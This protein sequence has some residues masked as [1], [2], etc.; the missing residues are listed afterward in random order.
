M[1]RTL[2]PRPLAV[3][4]RLIALGLPLAGFATSIA[5]Q[6]SVDAALELPAQQVTAS[7]A[8]R[9]DGPVDGYVA[10]RSVTGTKTDTPLLEVPQSISVITADRMQDQ[11]VQTVQDALRYVAGVRGEAFGLDTRGDWAKVRGS[12]PEL[13]LDGLQQ[14]FGYYNN[15]RTDPYT[16]ERIE[17]L[18][19]PSSM[20]Y[21]QSPVG[22]LVNLVS[23]RPQ[24]EPRTELQAQYGNYDHKQIALDSTGPLNEDGSLLYRVVAIAR[25]S[26][27]QVDYVESD[28]L[29]LM[30]SITWRPNDDI[31][32]TL[33]ANVQ[34]DDGGS[35]SQFL[36][37]EGTV[38]GAPYGRYDTDL[39]V[40][41][42]GFDEYDAEQTAL[43]SQ[44]SWRLNETWT[45]RQNL[46]YQESEV[47][48]QQIYGW[49]P[50]LNTDKRTLDRI[51]YVSKPEV[52][53]WVADHNAQALFDTGP[54][55]HTLLIGADYQH[56]VTNERSAG[57]AATPL[58]L[59]DPVY[60][61]FDPSV[62]SLVD[63]PEQT[64]VQQGIYVQDQLKYQRWLLTLGLRKDWADNRTDGGTRQKDDAVTGRVGLTYLFDNGVAPYISYSES[65]QPIIG[66][67]KA[68]NEPFTPLEGE[69]WEVGVKYQ[70]LG[71]RSLYTAA[72][73]DLRELNRQMP[74]PANP[75]NTLQA[76]ET[77][78]RGL[79]L[80]ALVSVTPNWDLIATYTHLDTEVI[81]GA[82]G[83]V[84]KRL[85]SIPENMASLWSQHQ[86]A[87]FGVPG[88]RAGA[89]VRYVGASWDGADDVK[90]PSTTLFDAMLGY[91][92]QNW[93]FAVN[94]T[95][96]EDETYYTSCLA[97]GDCFTGSRR[98]VVGT[99]SYSF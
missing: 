69:Q 64:V 28:R 58:D 78:T 55:Q 36:P 76:G 7:P 91:R 33:L 81:E 38:F 2:A 56:A 5:A 90:T 41:E 99:V 44:F 45:L 3:A 63:S 79:E 97:R 53:V 50:V 47:S 12:S 11:G 31:E 80:E 94:A 13:F 51:Y 34:R 18:K 30:P 39:F 98:T 77:R 49:P 61:T 42:P 96:L 82:P 62:I 68:N 21:G 46:R 84:G 74:D 52:D 22:G 95:N 25:D 37:H 8:E 72:V 86:F 87:L 9:A 4:L 40:S 1:P 15:I 75:N 48:Y 27:S 67:N 54:I 57:G 29:V 65:F 88:F 85:A 92:Y 59:Y 32:W 26:Q 14:T 83:E 24:A 16:L 10:T 19:G 71:S 73:F 93:D 20:L 23:K 35:T 17:V 70:P 89:G 43:T 66:L 60:G 6:E